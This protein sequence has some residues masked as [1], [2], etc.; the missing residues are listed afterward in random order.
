MTGP[1]KKSG[2]GPTTNKG[3]KTSSQNALIHGAT[4][5]SV[6]NEQQKEA[7]DRYVK[8]LTDFYRPTSPLEMLQIERIALCK[9]KLDS[10]YDLER[11]KL[12]IATEDLHRTPSLAMQRVYAGGGITQDFAESISKGREL[13][14][15]FKLTPD[16]LV[17]FALEI[18]GIGGQLRPEDEIDSVLPVLGKFINQTAKRLSI[19]GEQALLRLGGSI[20]EMLNVG[21][22]IGY[23][24]Q[25]ILK[26]QLKHR[27]DE[28][29]GAE[30]KE[31]PN[32]AQDVDVE[33][34]NDVLSSLVELNNIVKKSYEVAEDFS[35]MHALMLR[36][37]TL[38]ADESDRLMRYQTT[39][40]RRL[41]SAIGELLALQAKDAGKR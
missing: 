11:V 30:P 27:Q 14:L 34:I 41:S 21:N 36:A 22:A 31:D 18:S 25:Q 12:Q 2:G 40:E 6:T 15:P 17:E 13:D 33:K 29:Y 5:N 7:L 8:E 4:S 32:L 19:S 26:L 39:W 35:R 3:K 24:I 1:K 38:T 9:V 20:D 16:L 37:V 28:I 23:K 10:L